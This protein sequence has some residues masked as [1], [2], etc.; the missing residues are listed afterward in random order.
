MNW[1][2]F[3]HLYLLSNSDEAPNKWQNFMFPVRS[4]G[5]GGST[6]NKPDSREGKTQR[7]N[8]TNGS[9]LSSIKSIKLKE[10]VLEILSLTFRC[11]TRRAGQNRL[12]EPGLLLDS[13]PD[14]RGNIIKQRT[15]CWFWQ[16][17][18]CRQTDRQTSSAVIGNQAKKRL[19][20]RTDQNRDKQNL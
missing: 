11:R 15:C 17:D 2:H 19:R 8:K 3:N 9:L 18:S 14:L 5:S 12:T 16:L 20:I 1:I 13:L 4:S 6:K 7:R 10:G